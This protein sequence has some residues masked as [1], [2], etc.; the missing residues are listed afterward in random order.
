M[1]TNEPIISAYRPFTF[2]PAGFE[3]L[4]QWESLRLTAYQDVGGIWT[5][6]FGTTGELSA[7]GLYRDVREGDVITKEQ[8]YALMITHLHPVMEAVETATGMST[9]FMDITDNQYSAL[10]CFCY[11]IGETA[12]EN[13]TLATL[14]SR[15]PMGE[16][17][18]DSRVFAQLRRWNKVRGTVVEGLKNRRE[19]EIK[20]WQTPDLTKVVA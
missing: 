4:A 9:E 10:C 7:I 13:S 15:T 2:S 14:L 5:I 1:S 20:L 18:V 19:A 11:N 16:A 12:F 17:P 8:A 6:G 3:L